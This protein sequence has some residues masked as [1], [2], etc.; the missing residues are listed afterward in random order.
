MN[1]LERAVSWGVF[2][3]GRKVLLLLV[4]VSPSLAFMKITPKSYI[5][6]SHAI[7]QGHLPAYEL[8]KRVG[9]NNFKSLLTLLYLK[10]IF[11]NEE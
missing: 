9:W 1:V 2:D 7:N 4:S 10:K 3:K 6:I 11:P 8:L 5:I